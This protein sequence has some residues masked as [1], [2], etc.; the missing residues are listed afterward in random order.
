[1]GWASFAAGFSWFLRRRVLPRGNQCLTRPAF[2]RRAA[3]EHFGWC[4]VVLQGRD[5][6]LLWIREGAKAL[7]DKLLDGVLVRLEVKNTVVHSGNEQV[8]TVDVDSAKHLSLPKLT[9]PR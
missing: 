2:H 8:I 5:F 3:A 1:M 7:I 4:L 6:S 9:D